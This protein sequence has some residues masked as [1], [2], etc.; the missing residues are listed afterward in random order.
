MCKCLRNSLSNGSTC[1][2]IRVIHLGTTVVHVTGKLLATGR[3]Q[4]FVEVLPELGLLDTQEEGQNV[5]S[6]IN[7][8]CPSAV[9]RR[10]CLHLGQ[11]HRGKVSG[12]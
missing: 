5:T 7:A 3:K 2:S 8:I 10:R 9:C 12:L 6:I 11:I 1:I 4:G